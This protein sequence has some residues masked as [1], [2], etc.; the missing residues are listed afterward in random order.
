MTLKKKKKSAEFPHNCPLHPLF[1][2]RGGTKKEKDTLRR[3]FKATKGSEAAAP[4]DAYS[5]KNDVVIEL[6]SY[7]LTRNIDKEDGG[8]N[9]K[10]N[11]IHVLYKVGGEVL[12]VNIRICG[13]KGEEGKPFV[14]TNVVCQYPII[15]FDKIL[16]QII[17]DSDNCTPPNFDFFFSTPCR[18]RSGIWKK[19]NKL[20][21]VY[22]LI[23]LQV[24]DANC[25]LTKSWRNNKKKN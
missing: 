7:L 2:V 15:V 9:T 18:E 23:D 12:L 3:F 6:G 8:W 5:Q 25:M 24:I 10:D 1:P 11:T 20:H 4:S 17:D 21:V 22:N 13:R 19:E 14:V 16:Q